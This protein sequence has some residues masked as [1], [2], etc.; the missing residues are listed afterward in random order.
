MAKGKAKDKAK[1]DTDAEVA[2]EMEE[3]YKNA[4]VASGVK[5]FC[6]FDK[7][8]DLTKLIPNPRNPNKHPTTQ[9]E[10]LAKIIMNQ[11]WRAPVTVSRRSG[12]IVRGHGRYEAAKLMQVEEVPVDYQNYASDA[13]EWADLIADNRIAELSRMDHSGLKDLLTEID[14]GAF[15]MDLTGFDMGSLEDLMTRGMPP[16][17]DPDEE[18]EGMPDFDQQDKTPFRSLI[19][20]F[21][22]EEGVAD[23]KKVVGQDFSDLAKFIYHPEAEIDHVADKRWV[24]D[25]GE[26]GEE[27]GDTAE[28]A[29][30]DEGDE[31]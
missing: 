30:G 14:S 9:V 3:A 11:G 27:S 23:F 8:V 1:K 12:F 15:D 19:V 4:P 25:E 6:A 5:V 28:P 17:N 18:W 2:A 16:A 7:V 22:D 31:G 13:E 29:E 26:E 10:M 20:H 21:V 24:G